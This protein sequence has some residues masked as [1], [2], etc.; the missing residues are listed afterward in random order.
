MHGLLIVDMQND[1]LPGGA[2]AV[3]GADELIPLINE[4]QAHFELVVASQDWHPRGHVSFAST[5]GKQPMET[6]EIE[7]RFYTLWPDHCIQNTSGA[8][9]PVQLERGRWAHIV[10]KGMEAQVESYSAFF[11]ERGTST[12]LQPFLAERGVTS[13]T[14]VGV[15]TDYCV[16]QTVLDACRIGLRVHVHTAACRGI[17]D[18]AA[19]YEQM[20]SCGALIDHPLYSV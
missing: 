1:F 11:D 12:G 6:L 15:A 9:F 13:L 20:R 7:G 3:P 2:L 19:A 14:V 18:S 8:A 5:H 16:K 17:H 4:L 10:R